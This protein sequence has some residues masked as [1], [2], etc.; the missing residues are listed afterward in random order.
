MY[1]PNSVRSVLRRTP[2]LWIYQ[3]YQHMWIYQHY[4]HRKYI[5]SWIKAG[6][7]ISQLDA[8][9]HQIVKE[10]ASRFNL[11]VF[12]ETGTHMG[13]MVNAVKDT[14]DEIYS[15]E[16]DTALYEYSRSRFVDNKHI[17]I[18]KGDSSKILS[19]VLSNIDKPCLFFL[20]AHCSGFNL[21]TQ[22]E[23]ETAIQGE[24][25]CIFQHPISNQHVILIDNAECFTGE[26]DYPTIGKVRE[27]ARL[28]G[29]DS[30]EVKDD[31]IRLHKPTSSA[32][33]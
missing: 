25:H 10:Y 11:H 16:L 1:L 18:I 6:S 32:S 20:D 22:G 7:P 12:V 19:K 15:I 3:Q 13:I 31:V 8:K 21:S 29:F 2:A 27:M 17:R 14:F 30:F 9:N 5:R 23:R 28:A 26:H 4:Q 33:N 24:L